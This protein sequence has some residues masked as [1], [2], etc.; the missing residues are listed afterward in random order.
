MTKSTPL[1]RKLFGAYSLKFT[2]RIRPKLS[3]PSYNI[4]CRFKPSWDIRLFH[5]QAEVTA[6]HDVKIQ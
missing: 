1:A 5:D 6:T 2:D 3:L 4:P